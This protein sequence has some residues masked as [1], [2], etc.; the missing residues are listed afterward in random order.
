MLFFFAIVILPYVLLAAGFL[1]LICLAYQSRSPARPYLLYPTICS[2]VVTIGFTTWGHFAIITSRSS[3]AAIGYIFLPFYSVAV[4]LVA[5]LVSWSLL[6]L[7]RLFISRPEQKSNRLSLL[8]PV[9]LAVMV[10]SV[11]GFIAWKWVSR[12]RLLNIAASASSPA[13]LEAVLDNAISSHDLDVLSNLAK[14]PNTSPNELIRIFD[15]CKDQLSDFNP[16]EYTVYYSLAQ[17]PNTPPDKLEVL[18]KCQQSTVRLAVGMNPSTPIT[19]LHKLAKDND[20]QVRTW[21]TTN[22]KIPKELLLELT[23]DP[24]RIVRSYAETHLRY[25]GFDKEKQEED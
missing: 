21:L 14:N 3:T 19:I 9:G 5:F 10:L 6:F 4:A 22:D 23:E 13:E 11:T 7:V 12:T 1:L 24:D 18:A 16:L 2:F 8:L 17:N 25:R 15:S 20:A